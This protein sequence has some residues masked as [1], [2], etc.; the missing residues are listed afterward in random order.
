MFDQAIEKGH[1]LLPKLRAAS[2]LANKSMSRKHTN[3]SDLSLC[4]PTYH[5]VNK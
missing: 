2:T 3:V 4:K 5:Y 1:Y